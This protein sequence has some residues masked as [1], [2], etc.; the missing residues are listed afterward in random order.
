[1]MGSRLAVR[2]AAP[3]S[4]MHDV[5]IAG[6]GPAGAMA[7]T[8]LAR[9]GARVLV[10]DRARFP[11]A[12][13]CGDTLNPGALAVLRR[14]GLDE[15]TNGSLALHGMIITGEDG[16]RV[17]A[18]YERACG[19]AIGRREFDLAL[20]MAAARAGAHV[21]Q[22]VLVQEAIVDS[23]QHAP[24]VAGLIVKGRGKS[25]RIT[26]P[27]VIAADGR[28][29]RVA[30]TLGLS[31][32]AANPRRWAI[33]AYFENVGGTTAFGE[34]HVRA[35]HY[36]GIA[37]LPGGFTNACV[38]TANPGRTLPEN[39]LLAALRGDVHL[40]DRFA[41]ARMVSKPVSLG[42]L[43]V[44]CD[45]AG[46]HGLLLAG[47]A[48]GFVDPMTGDGLRFAL[49]GGELA[50]REALHALEHGT[51]SAH[52]RL[53]VARRREFAAKWRFNRTMRWL[54][55]YPGAVRVAGYGAAALPQLLRQAVQYA[56]DV[57]AA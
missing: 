20:L 10:F 7:A 47:D 54:V 32:A 14:L 12:K 9:A 57:H 37:P 38:V 4:E 25:V 27:L 52:V 45:V 55:G 24:R 2:T 31:R 23:S 36:M 19:Y 33:G 5:L 17:E 26:A 13:L 15:A 41:D 46:A 16:V 34:M 21:E 11:R 39:A 30:R 56:G 35:T 40:R 50:A 44:D 8:L 28:Y 6:A 53:Q 49:R 22:D 3:I 42:P 51:A 18:R 29:S 48:S 43:G 1:M